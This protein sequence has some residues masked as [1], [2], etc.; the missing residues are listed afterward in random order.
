MMRRTV[1]ALL[2]AMLL[3]VSLPAAAVS[4]DSTVVDY[5]KLGVHLQCSGFSGNESFVIQVIDE[6]KVEKSGNLIVHIPDEAV[7]YLGAFEADAE[8]NA[9]ITLSLSDTSETGEKFVRISSLYGEKAEDSF[10]IVSEEKV[11][12]VFSLFTQAVNENDVSKLFSILNDETAITILFQKEKLIEI[13]NNTKEEFVKSDEVNTILSASAPQNISDIGEAV[14]KVFTPYAAQRV[15]ETAELVYLLENFSDEIGINSNI[16]SEI[17][18]GMKPDVKEMAVKRIIDCSS[19]S[20]TEFQK[21]FSEK[22]LLTAVKYAENT[23]KVYPVISKY[24]PTIFGLDTSA[25]ESLKNRYPVDGGLLESNE[26]LETYAQFKKLFDSLVAMEKLKEGLGSGSSGGSGSGGGGGGFSS[27]SVISSEYYADGTDNA[28]LPRHIEEEYFSDL[29]D[30]LWAEESI[31]KLYYMGVVNGVQVGLYAPER[32]VTR[33]EFAKL[34]TTALGMVDDE[35][36][37]E[38]QD[39]SAEDWSYKYIASA[40]EKG[41]VNGT[42]DTT[43]E[44]DSTI[45]RE[46]MAVMC[47]NAMK[48]Y[49]E[50]IFDTE[51]EAAVTEFEDSE[52]IEPY[53]FYAV[54]T[55]NRKGIINGTGNNF[56]E[57]KLESTRAEAAVIICRMLSAL[58]IE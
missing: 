25:Y 39:V 58:D 14:L 19:K 44:P 40:F 4:I 49:K 57:P 9:A 17:Y 54:S 2:A 26:E 12:S 50:T 3:L 46:Q 42:S 1:S 27:G 37:C 47:C 51:E 16:Y 33:A 15:N 45:T 31:L 28:Q 52:S 48:A 41:V 11:K 55:L 10:Y 32:A 20:I 8:G 35:A 30:Y 23:T 18:A 36:K 34:I 13:Y 24:F 7:D 21:N 53:A 22:V 56:F 38:F 43:F 6:N 29:S 5:D